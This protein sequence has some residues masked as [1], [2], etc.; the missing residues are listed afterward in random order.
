VENMADD[1]T[2]LVFLAEVAITF[3]CSKVNSL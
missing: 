1:L 2:S 3:R